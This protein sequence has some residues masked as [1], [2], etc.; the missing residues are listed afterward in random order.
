LSIEPEA[1]P[2]T[3]DYLYEV[4]SIL[5]RLAPLREM[6]LSGDLR[7]LYLAWL[8]P[9]WDEE[10]I[11]PPVPAGLGK[12]DRALEALAEFYEISPDLITAA[13]EQSPA[14]AKKTDRHSAARKWID[15]LSKVE[16]KQIVDDLVS[17]DAAIVRADA[18]SQIR[19][20]VP[21]SPPA[22]AM[23]SRTFGQINELAIL[24]GSDRKKNADAAK[25]KARK[26]HL[27]SIAANPKKTIRRIDTLVAGRTRECYHQV[28]D[29]LTDLAEAL[30]A[31]PGPENARQIAQKLRQRKP[32]SNVLIGVLRKRGW[33]D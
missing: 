19:R 1:E 33:I 23:P 20:S 7:P 21:V 12:T 18:L 4:H 6:I 5:H 28:A 27:K 25:A 24:V 15:G 10:A 11:E 30:G 3:Y 14:A 22:T 32:R 17:K 13:A 9:V 31:G 2:D 16:L 26:K 29:C 8:A